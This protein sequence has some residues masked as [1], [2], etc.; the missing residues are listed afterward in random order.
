M[1]PRWTEGLRFAEVKIARRSLVVWSSHTVVWAW[2]S[3]D[4]VVNHCRY[5]HKQL[6]DP[7]I[8][9]L[10]RPALGDTAHQRSLSCWISRAI[11]FFRLCSPE[12]QK[13]W[14]LPSLTVCIQSLDPATCLFLTSFTVGSRLTYAEK[15]LLLLPNDTF[16]PSLQATLSL[17]W[18]VS[19]GEGPLALYRPGL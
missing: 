4:E 1:R 8:L 9:A 13:P 10:W 15:L 14:C 11:E 16:F 2:A 19:K 7:C 6:C 17:W 18:T 3:L 5:L 12:T